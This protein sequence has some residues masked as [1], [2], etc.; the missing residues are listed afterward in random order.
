MLDFPGGS[1]VKNSPASAGDTGSIPGSGVSPGGGNGTHFDILASKFHEQRS[2]VGYSPW[3]HK[4]LDMIEQLST[5]THTYTH[6]HT[7]TY[8]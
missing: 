1:V 6:T 3:R 2:L 7:H 4:G 5:H 8:T